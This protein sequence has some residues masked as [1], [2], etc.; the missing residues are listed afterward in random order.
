L[1]RLNRSVT[2]EQGLAISGKELSVPQQK[3]VPV[4]NQW[5]DWSAKP[6][7]HGP[8][9]YWRWNKSAIDQSKRRL[10]ERLYVIAC[11]L[12]TALHDRHFAKERQA[13]TPNWSAIAGYYSMVHALRLV[14]FVLYGSYPTGHRP[15]A[16]A[17]SGSLGAIANWAQE[18]GVP[19][20]KAKVTL[21][22]LQ[23]AIREGF[24]CPDL[25]DRLQAVGRVFGA[26][27]ALREDS[28]YESLI[29]AHQYF[30]IPATRG[31]INVPKEF[32]KAT[33]AMLDANQ[34]VVQF[35]SDLLLASFKEDVAWYCPVAAFSAAHLLELTLGYVRTKMTLC[36]HRRHGPALSE[37]GWAAGLD[38]LE[39]RLAE[40][41]DQ[42]GA[43]SLAKY[44]RFGEFEMKRGI[45]GEFQ[46]KVKHLK[47][48]VRPFVSKQGKGFSQPRLFSW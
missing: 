31:L 39:E 14:W 32:A 22:A 23:S 4:S 33:G 45:L 42:A 17:L 9:N 34:I 37:A 20:G 8:F 19:E 36:I 26:A 1:R 11:L 44:W 35:V 46:T 15:M 12:W 2:G 24:G 7:E 40:E 43:K 16:N 21:R 47:D 41:G 13:D 28:N 10:G 18:K 3:K 29:L 25:A 27:I 48:I 38:G 5:T 30:H 6:A